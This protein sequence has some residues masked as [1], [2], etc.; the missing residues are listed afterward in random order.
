MTAG[1]LDKPVTGTEVFA[2]TLRAESRFSV[3]IRGLVE[4]IDDR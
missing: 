1:M 3:L 4:R 2:I